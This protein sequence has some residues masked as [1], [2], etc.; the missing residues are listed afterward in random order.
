MTE[1]Y[2]EK[3]KPERYFARSLQVVPSTLLS[4]TVI[5]NEADIMK[6]SRAGLL[7]RL[8]GQEVN[9]DCWDS[10]LVSNVARGS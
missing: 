8:I 6:F 5:K 3:V 10:W 4:C 9:T 7:Y 1:A 2:F